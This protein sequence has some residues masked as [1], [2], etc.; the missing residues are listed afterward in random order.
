[1]SR[2]VTA[3]RKRKIKVLKA[4]AKAGATLTPLAD[5][6]VCRLEFSQ[7]EGAYLIMPLGELQ[8]LIREG[9]ICKSDEKLKTASAGLMHLRRLLLEVDEFQDQHREIAAKPIAREG[10]S[11]MRRVNEA[12]SPLA[13]LHFRTTKKGNPYIDENAYQ[14]GERL[15]ADFTRANLSQQISSSWNAVMGEGGRT[16]YRNGMGDISD[17]ALSARIR[18]E[19]AL[20][21]VGPEFAGVLVDI[22]CFLKGLELVERE[23]KWPPR[24]AKLM[25][26]TG[27][28]MLS[29]HY[30][31]DKGAPRTAITRNWGDEDYRPAMFTDPAQ[32]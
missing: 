2:T 11:V 5:D 18:M 23:R 4:C 12:E 1:M 8:S 14:A 28:S 10:Q 29:R 24:S 19:K 3:K 15:R 30:G 25:L 9:L 13:R 21:A 20:E 31:F 6:S 26:R 27:L 22:C 17:A 16:G 32:N 7:P